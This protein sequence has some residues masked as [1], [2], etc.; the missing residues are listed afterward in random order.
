MVTCEEARQVKNGINVQGQ[1]VDKGEV[2]TVNTWH[3]ETKVCD[4]YLEDDSGRIQL[5]LWDKDTE[6]VNNGDH[7]FT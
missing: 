7:G 4:A 3:G 2:R 1:I 5:T 6:K